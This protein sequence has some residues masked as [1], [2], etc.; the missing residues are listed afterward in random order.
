ML[1]AMWMM[2]ACRNAAVISRPPVA[3]VDERPP[4]DH[5]VPERAARC[6]EPV[7]LHRGQEVDRDVDRDQRLR[8]ERLGTGDARLWQHDLAACDACAAAIACVV[9]AAKPD[10]RCGHALGADGSA[11]FRAREPRL[12]VRMPVA[13]RQARLGG[14][15][16]D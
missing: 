12:A 7:S 8:D 10:R 6:A 16:H 2:L 4:E 3:V 11:A 9:G 13:R 15:H 1:N 14:R 5:L